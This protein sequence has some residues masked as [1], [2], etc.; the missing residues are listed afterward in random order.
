[1]AEWVIRLGKKQEENE[2]DQL[3]QQTR[4]NMFLH[5]YSVR[6]C[7]ARFFLR[8]PSFSYSD[9][10]FNYEVLSHIP[11]HPFGSELLLSVN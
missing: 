3:L 6:G 4:A 5:V 8:P 7:Y 10:H 1:M 9:A 2:I 11:L